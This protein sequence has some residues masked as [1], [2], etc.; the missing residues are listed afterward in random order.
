M[1][2]HFPRHGVGAPELTVA[3]QRLTD[4]ALLD[5][6]EQR[7]QHGNDGGYLWQAELEGYSDPEINDAVVRATKELTEIDREMEGL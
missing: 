3:E 7:E 6:I 2:E 4:L 5:L 1:S